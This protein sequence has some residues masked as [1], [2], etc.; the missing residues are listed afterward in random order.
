MKNL[1]LLAVLI[2]AVSFKIGFNDTPQC[3]KKIVDI[4]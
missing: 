1:I 4:R 3:C 2:A